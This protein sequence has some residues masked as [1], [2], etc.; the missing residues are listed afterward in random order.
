MPTQKPLA[1][2]VPELLSFIRVEEQNRVIFNDKLM[3]IYNGNL[4]KF[5][6]ESCAVE[7][8]PA[9]CKKIIQRIPPINLLN[10]VVSKLSKVYDTEPVRSC[11]DNEIDKKLFNYYLSTLSIDSKFQTS[12]ELL[13]LH[14]N[15]ALEPY[16]NEGIPCI[17][18]LPANTYLVYSDDPVNPAQMTV[19]IKFMGTVKKSTPATDK[20]G[21]PLRNAESVVRDVKLFYVYSD[22]EFMILDADGVIQSN[23]INPVGKIP[24]VYANASQFELIPT[25]D[26]DNY[27][28]SVLIPKL[29]ADLN[30]A[31]M[32]SSHS[33]V[34]GVDVEFPSDLSRSPDDIWVLKSTIGANGE[35]TAPSLNVLKPNVDIAEV[36]N[37]INQTV[38]LWLDTKGIKSSATGNTTVQAASSGIAKMIDE[39][40]ATS[41]IK[42]QMILFNK[43]EKDLWNLIKMMHNYWLNNSMLTEVSQNFSTTFS[44]SIKFGEVKVIPNRK[45]TL[46]ELK[47]EFDM[48][49]VT[50]KQALERLNPGATKDVIER[51]LQEIEADANVS[52]EDRQARISKIIENGDI[53]DTE[54]DNE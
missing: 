28:I 54:T 24:F 32:Y 42:K 26:S 22:T 7:Y 4:L 50:V 30:Y 27:N 25:P 43:I 40:D 9:T 10:K 46:D 37:L 19:F 34:Y 38:S 53:E 17:R 36:L 6:E 47:V 13:N 3:Q 18:I 11:N 29:L 5:V 51:L 45:D 16:V 14:K 41:L 35:K 20:N 49:L 52:D 39:G 8:S 12:N 33:I 15:F 1:Q 21:K 48:K 23:V 31:V 44:P 2:M